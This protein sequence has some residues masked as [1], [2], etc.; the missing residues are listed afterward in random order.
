M[1]VSSKSDS[2]RTSLRILF[3]S[4]E[5]VCVCACVEAAYEGRSTLG[6]QLQVAQQCVA[7]ACCDCEISIFSHNGFAGKESWEFDRSS[8][9]IQSKEGVILMSC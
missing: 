7:N 8:V 5:S 3:S 2:L 9:H 1:C 6:L 4:L